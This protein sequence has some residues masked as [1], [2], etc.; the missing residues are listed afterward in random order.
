MAINQGREKTLGIGREACH[1]RLGSIGTELEKFKDHLQ[2][3]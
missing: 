1:K 2:F 3:L